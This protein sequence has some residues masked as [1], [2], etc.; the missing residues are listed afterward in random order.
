MIT[1]ITKRCAGCAVLLLCFSFTILR[2]H[3]AAEQQPQPM[4]RFF[5]NKST[6]ATVTRALSGQSEPSDS[7]DRLISEKLR[8]IAQ[9][10]DANL[11]AFD[12]LLELLPPEKQEYIE[13]LPHEKDQLAALV[14][15]LRE[16]QEPV[17]ETIDQV[18][19]LLAQARI[20]IRE[21]QDSL[22]RY[23]RLHEPITGAFDTITT[24]YMAEMSG[25]D[26]G[27]RVLTDEDAIEILKKI[28]PLLVHT[29]ARLSPILE[30]YGYVFDQ[31][32]ADRMPDD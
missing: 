2:L 22:N 19:E 13:A 16:Q 8:R 11:A 31:Q 17:N 28:R 9:Q 24:Q 6:L 26:T 12:K 21:Y 18:R 14:Q 1:T 20:D 3:A 29:N 7:A 32:A 23:Y 15:A 30:R 27:R 4:K 10:I 25:V 5:A